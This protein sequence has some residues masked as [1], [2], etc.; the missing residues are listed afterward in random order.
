MR[1]FI[2]FDGQN[3]QKAGSYTE[4]EAT[5]PTE[6]WQ[7]HDLGVCSDGVN[8]VYGFS[9]GS[10]SQPMI[11]MEGTIHGG[12]EWRCAHWLKMFMEIM[13]NPENYPQA[14][15]IYKIRSKF[16]IY[17]IPCLNPYG[18]ENNNYCNANG[19]NLNR[20]F[21]A[22]WSSFDDSND[23]CTNGK[24]PSAFSE[25]EAQM[26]RDLVQQFKPIVF[27]DNHTWG[28]Y[29]GSHL[30]IELSGKEYGIL[31]E[32][33]NKSLRLTLGR[34]DL[35]LSYYGSQAPRSS[36]W[37]GQQISKAGINTI[38]I[39]FEPGSLE[40]EKEQARIG[41]NAMFLICYYTLRWFEERRLILN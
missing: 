2:A 17:V 20:N 14:E 9:L 24:G 11:F 1:K 6:G 30:E 13:S 7:T 18:Y 40:A 34:N 23:A 26:V 21:D 29:E 33:L 28:G 8:H 41:I 22:Y 12:H 38:P 5:L 36:E 35:L 15:V 37:A 4:L 32:D 31:L 27:V 19:V 3:F 16:C 25:P 10:L 39:T